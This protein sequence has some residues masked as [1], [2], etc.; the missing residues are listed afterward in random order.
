MYNHGR[1]NL[2]AFN[3]GSVAT[4]REIEFEIIA[5]ENF[6]ALI[7]GGTERPLEI[8]SHNTISADLNL[9]AMF[10]LGIESMEEINFFG[11]LY[12]VTPIRFDVREDVNSNVHASKIINLQMPLEENLNIS[13]FVGK[14]MPTSVAYEDRINTNVYI[15]KLMP[16]EI[17]G[18]EVIDMAITAGGLIIDNIIIDVN[19]PPG[20]EFTI[21]S[22]VFTAWLHP[23]INIL[24]LYRGEWVHLTREVV[25]LELNSAGGNINGELIY[26]ERFL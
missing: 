12:A 26:N 13:L 18:W 16:S 4:E 17:D 14:F 20:G 2:N 1:F 3:V 15:G 7:G 22:D 11:E 19:I 5:Y 25:G 6:D 24:H 21:N 9:S 23:D 10:F 8:I